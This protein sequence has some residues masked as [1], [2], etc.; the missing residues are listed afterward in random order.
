MAP[1]PP[2][3]PKPQPLRNKAPHVGP[4]EMTAEKDAS[5]TKGAPKGRKAAWKGPPSKKA[6]RPRPSPRKK[7]PNPKDAAPRVGSKKETVIDLLS[8]RMAQRW[9][10]SPKGTGWQSHSIRGFVSGT[11]TKKM[12]LPVAS[13]KNESG[14]R[15]FASRW[16][17]CLSS[18]RWVAPSTNGRTSGPK[19]SNYVLICIR[20]ELETCR[21]FAS[22]AA[23]EQQIRDREAAER[24][25]RESKKAYYT[26][27]RFLPRVTCAE[28]SKDSRR[29]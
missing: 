12:D 16:C 11:L 2:R 4:K 26:V 6:R 22:L 28:E 21:T 1:Q 23:T 13:P 5:K 20:T 29:S 25:T 24:C 8:A 19:P 9:L 27:I 17:G 10:K 14:E 7:P 18:E 3:P 15:V